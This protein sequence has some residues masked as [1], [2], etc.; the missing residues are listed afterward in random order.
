ME[1][2][3]VTFIFSMFLFSSMGAPKKSFPDDVNTVIPK[4]DSIPKGD[5]MNRVL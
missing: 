1:L 5:D 3:K 2:V 4:G